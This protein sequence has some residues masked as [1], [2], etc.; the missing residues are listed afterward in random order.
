MTLTVGMITVDSI[1]PGPLAQWWADQTGGTASDEGGGYFYIVTTPGASPNLGFQKVDEPTPG[2]NRL[3]LD[4]GAPDLDTEVARL[5]A[6]GATEYE[7]HALEGFRWVTLTD[8]EGNRFCVA[9][10]H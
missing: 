10:G 5:V 4:F 3:H 1:D 8:P 9:D 6:A 2:K 7:R